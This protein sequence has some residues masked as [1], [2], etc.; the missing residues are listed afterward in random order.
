MRVI[1]KAAI[2]NLILQAEENLRGQVDENFGNKMY[3]TDAI[4]WMI[5]QLENLKK[6]LEP[7]VFDVERR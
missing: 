7:F 1:E 5:K 3:A 6:E 2:N 4:F